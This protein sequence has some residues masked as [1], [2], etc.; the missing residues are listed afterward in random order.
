MLK[1]LLLI[2][3][4][5]ILLAVFLSNAVQNT[6]AAVRRSDPERGRDLFHTLQPGA[7]VT[8][9][10]CHR[11]HSEERLVGPGL[12]HVSARA[13]NRLP[14]ATA[15]RYLYQSI[16]NPSAY[17]VDGYPDIMPKNWGVIFSDEDLADL[18]AYLMALD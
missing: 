14:D 9:S 16:T 11:T 13:G 5:L 1:I 10:T 17:M 2:P 18:I 15:E 8:C 6:G 7:T 4:F 12:M 3:L